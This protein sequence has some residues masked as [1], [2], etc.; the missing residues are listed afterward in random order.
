MFLPVVSSSV[1]KRFSVYFSKVEEVSA[2]VR[3]SESMLPTPQA[4][5]RKKQFYQLQL[6]PIFIFSLF[7][8]RNWIEFFS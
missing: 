4:K 3:D 1:L 2:S 6:K 5:F 7:E 8:Y